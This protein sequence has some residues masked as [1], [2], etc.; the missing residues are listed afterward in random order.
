[1]RFRVRSGEIMLKKLAAISLI[2]GAAVFVAPAVATA[3][4]SYSDKSSVTVDDPIIDNCDVSTIMFGPGSF[5]AGETVGVSISGLDAADAA[6]SGN[7]AAGDGSLTVTFRPPRS[8]SGAYAIT[9]T[10][11]AGATTARVASIASIGRYTAVITVDGRTSTCPREPAV[12]AAAGSELPLSADGSIELA[13]TGGGVSPW[14][15]GGGAA[16][17]VAGGGLFA[18]GIARRKRSEI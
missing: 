13:L 6:L 12:S 5:P 4:D 18:V 17:L 10:S 11:S 7:V 9:F 15:V 16:A 8:G 2:A 14:L 1:M 3:D